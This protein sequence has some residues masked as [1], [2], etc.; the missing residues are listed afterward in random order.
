VRFELSTGTPEPIYAQIARQVRSGIAS[1]ALAPGER[2]PS[3]RRLARELVVNP[4]TVQKAYAE[5]ER[6]GLVRTKRGTGTFVATGPPSAASR[7]DARGRFASLVEALL[8]E[9][10]HAGFSAE[11]AIAEIRRRAGK[12][13]LAGQSVKE[14]AK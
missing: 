14:Q 11:E 13:R 4:N 6:A 7:A 8:V 1:A 5:L 2:L 3:V 10:V 12:Y 9:A